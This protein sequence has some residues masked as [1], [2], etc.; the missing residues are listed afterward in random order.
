MWRHDY[1]KQF[2]KVSVESECKS[3]LP[4]LWQQ[5]DHSK[6]KRIVTHFISI[7]QW[8][9]L[10]LFTKPSPQENIINLDVTHKWP[11]NIQLW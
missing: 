6:P 4:Q 9:E 11:N 7:V 2:W 5:C 8:L 10:F 3:M 1:W